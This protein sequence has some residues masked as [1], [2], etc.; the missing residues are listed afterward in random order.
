MAERG[1][2][3]VPP[4]APLAT[5]ASIDRP[6]PPIPAEPSQPPPPPLARRDSQG[7]DC[8]ARYQSNLYSN[9]THSAF[10][11]NPSPLRLIVV[12]SLQPPFSQL[13]VH[14]HLST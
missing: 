5:A 4:P 13:I 10:A 1:P 3:A 11:T 14:C 8:D 7:K 12:D 6:L 2:P 9:Q